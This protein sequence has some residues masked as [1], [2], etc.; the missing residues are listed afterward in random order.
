MKR[1]AEIIF[2]REETV[3]VR[4]DKT[5]VERFC[6]MCRLLVVMATPSAAS[7]VCGI[8]ERKIFRLLEAGAI[9]FTEDER[10]LICL[11]CCQRSWP[12]AE[13][14]TPDSNNF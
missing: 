9:Y 4:Q 13:I 14:E 2:E 1:R 7:A 5:T 6:P 3:V 11:D 10:I 8:A 12:Q